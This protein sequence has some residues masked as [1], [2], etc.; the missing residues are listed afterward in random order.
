MTAVIIFLGV[1]AAALVLYYTRNTNEADNAAWEAARA[2]EEDSLVGRVFMTGAGVFRGNRLVTN[3]KYDSGLGWLHRQLAQSGGLFGGSV[4][5]F[6]TVQLVAVGFATI[7]ALFGWMGLLPLWLAAGFAIGMVA[8]PYARLNEIV[9][10]RTRAI[11]AELPTFVDLLVIPIVAGVSIR[12]ALDQT[13]KRMDG[14]V[15]DEVRLA[16][17]DANHGMPLADALRRV[18]A[19]L[20]IP[21]AKTFFSALAQ[22]EAQGTTVLDQLEQ[23]RDALRHELYQQ[24]RSTIR[25]LPAQLTVLFVLHFMPLLFALLGAVMVTQLLGA[26]E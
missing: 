21:E 22:A 13:A 8:W 6:L 3:L 2:A 11:L 12:S 19:R 23:Y 7:V 15:A 25:K 9:K 18:A 26:F 16:V 4:E 17:E 20:A 10:K 24:R 1:V 5:V 14:P